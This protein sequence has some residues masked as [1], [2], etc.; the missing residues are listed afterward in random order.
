MLSNEE[1]RLLFRLFFNLPDSVLLDLQTD[2][3][4]N[5]VDINVVYGT[6]FNL[7]TRKVDS[8]WLYIGKYDLAKDIYYPKNLENNIKH[9][10]LK[11]V[12]QKQ[13][14]N[15]VVKIH[16]LAL[17]A[18]LSRRL[19]NDPPLI[20]ETSDLT[21]T[22]IGTPDDEAYNM[23]PFIDEHR[24]DL[25]DLKLEKVGTNSLARMMRGNDDMGGEG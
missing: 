11:P 20:I 1:L 10:E 25:E 8:K 15:Y 12:S 14:H 23:K 13:R 17:S 19:N 21:S 9:T 16:D 24:I 18:R 7:T 4:P 22:S 6:G 3:D 2:E 5:V